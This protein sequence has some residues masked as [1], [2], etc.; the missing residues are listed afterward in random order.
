[1]MAPRQ[2]PL[3][4]LLALVALACDPAF[5]YR[6]EGWDKTGR[7]EWRSR[8]EDFEVRTGLLGDLISS[9]GLVPEFE[10]VNHSSE[11]LAIEDA[12]LITQERNYP[13]KLP[14][15]GELRWR[16]AAPGSRARITLHW[17][18]EDYAIDVLGDHPRIV[19]DLRLGDEQHQVEI[20]YERIQ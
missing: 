7:Y 13:V 17:Q 16:S 18:F 9:R 19:L 6:P 4:F 20:E 10:L 15:Q 1:M 8:I 2:W 14:G 3:A 5:E 11:T 12:Y